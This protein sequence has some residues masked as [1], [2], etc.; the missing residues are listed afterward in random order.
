MREPTDMLIR[1][2]AAASLLVAGCASHTAHVG[3][4]A[5]KQ[6]AESVRE[7]P[8]ITYTPANWPQAL[9]GD[10]Y[11]PTGLAQPRPAV[12][13]V[14][15]GG[16]ERRTRADM[17]DIAAKL[18]KRGYVVFNISHRFAPQYQ[19]PAQVND[20]AQAVR[21][22]RRNA[23]QHN[24]DPDRIGG[25]GYSSGAHLVGM[26]GTLSPG[27]AHYPGDDTRLN[28]LVLGG[29]PADLRKFEGGRLVPQFLGATQAQNFAVY[30]QAS[31]TALV[32]GDDPPSFLYHGGMD[33]LVS[34][35]HARE[36]KAALDAADVPAELYIARLREHATMF[37]FGGGAEKAGMAFLDRALR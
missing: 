12:L 25:W 17:D 28:A 23:D 1:F 10:L 27:D 19:F 5:P 11:L 37:V 31:P 34:A 26:L 18:A 20:L 33:L 21:W 4:P 24:I 32:S 9:Q 16:W 22:M 6:R 29:T 8:N 30:E 2:F 7:I 36:M 35:D 3:D 13:L 15:G 14:H